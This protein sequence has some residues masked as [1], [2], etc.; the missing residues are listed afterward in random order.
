MSASFCPKGW[1]ESFGMMVSVAVGFLNISK[2]SSLAPLVIVRSRKF[3]F[4]SCSR[5]N[6]NTSP[7]VRFL[8]KLRIPSMFV[9]LFL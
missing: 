8:N 1:Y 6:V 7:G 9:R 5:S 4:L 2:V 3:I